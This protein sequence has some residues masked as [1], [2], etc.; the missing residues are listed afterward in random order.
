MSKADEPHDEALRSLDA[1]LAAV[2]GREA[3]KPTG[4]VE[5]GA[6]DGYRLLADLLGGV[7]GGL[8]L[9]WALDHYAGTRP[10]GLIGGVLIGTGLSVFLVVRRASQMSAKAASKA[11]T[12]TNDGPDAG[13]KPG[14]A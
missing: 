8:G 9:G 4:S 6:S 11:A 2:E 1:R 3:S 7:L 5:Q 10:W 14:D 13:T 12:E